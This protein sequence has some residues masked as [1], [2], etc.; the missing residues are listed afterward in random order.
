MAQDRADEFECPQWQAGYK[1]VRVTAGPQTIIRP[2][3]CKVCAQPFV[4]KAGEDILKY[5]LI[6]RRKT[7][8]PR[9]H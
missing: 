1:I 9:I 5:L 3:Q 8:G 2:I 6:D 4:S 7:G